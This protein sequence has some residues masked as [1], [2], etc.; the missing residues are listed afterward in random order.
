MVNPLS[1]INEVLTEMKKV[2]WPTRKQTLEKTALVIG[3][4]IIVGLYIGALDFIFSGLI[5]TLIS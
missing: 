2:S 4:S 5:N 1:Y 3:V